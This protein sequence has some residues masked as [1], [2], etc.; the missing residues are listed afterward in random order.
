MWLW[1]C[2]G[3]RLHARNVRWGSS[4]CIDK[5]RRRNTPTFYVDGRSLRIGKKS[6]N[7]STHREYALISHNTSSLHSLMGAHKPGC[8]FIWFSLYVFFCAILYHVHST[9]IGKSC[10]CWLI[11]FCELAS[12]E[13]VA[14]EF[15]SQIPTCFQRSFS[16][17]SDV[18]TSSV[19]LISN[20]WLLL[21]C[22]TVLTW[23]DNIN[24]TNNVNILWLARLRC[25]ERGC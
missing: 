17:L 1:C 20:L 9:Q 13:C 16:V 19:N 11:N 3:R 15:V 14:L 6:W 12:S 2:V 7:T 10:Y 24:A 5:R 18:M 23:K 25:T 21:S 22:C 8:S 4:R